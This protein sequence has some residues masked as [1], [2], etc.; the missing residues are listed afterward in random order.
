MDWWLSD[1]SLGEDVQN[2]IATDNQPWWMITVP[3][4]Y[5]IGFVI[6]VMWLNLKLLI[7]HLLQQLYDALD[8]VPELDTYIYRQET[9]SSSSSSSSTPTRRQPMD[10]TTATIGQQCAITNL[11]PIHVLLYLHT[12]YWMIGVLYILFRIKMSRGYVILYWFS[13]RTNR[14]EW[15]V[16]CKS[17][18]IQLW[19]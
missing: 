3:N 16:M 11:M 19:Y 12:S 14:L 18:E 6:Y 17:K 9:S 2:F 10:T 8:Y 5:Y 13:L 1:G 4:Y 15:Q 7:I